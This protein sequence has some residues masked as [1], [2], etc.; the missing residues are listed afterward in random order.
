M[1]GA[2]SGRAAGALALLAAGVLAAGTAAPAG[3]RDLPD[4][5]RTMPPTDCVAQVGY[6]QNGELTGY[7][8]R[9]QGG[10]VVCVPIREIPRVD[11]AKGED[12][13]IDRATF[14]AAVAALEACRAAGPCAAEAAAAAYVPSS[15][16]KTGTKDPVGLIDPFAPDVDLADIRRPAYFAQAPYAEPIAAAEDS[17]WTL[18]LAVPADPYDRL[19]RGETADTHLRGW[20]L[21][22]A[23]V[24]GPDGSRQR[25]LVVLIGGR[26]VETTATDDPRDPTYV[27]TADGRY[28]YNTAARGEGLGAH[29]WRGYLDTM[30]R[31]GFDVLTVDKR[32]HGISGGRTPDDLLNQGLDMLRLLDALDDGDGLRVL[33]PDG[34][35]RAGTAA[36]RALIPTAQEARTVPTVLGGSSQGSETTEF[37]MWANTARWC[38]YDEPG[39]PCHAPW[40]HENVRGAIMLSAIYSPGSY[41]AP[42]LLPSIAAGALRNHIMRYPTSEPLASIGRW[43]AVLNVKG[44]WDDLPDGTFSVYDAHRRAGDDAQLFLVRGP[45]SEV[46][47]GD[48]I[49]ARVRARM[50]DFATDA[51]RG[52]PVTQR[53]YADLQDAVAASWPVYE[54]STAPTVLRPARAR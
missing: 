22:G 27:R 9:Q 51:V 20:Y 42:G 33:G 32:G 26:T 34:A 36:A 47:W 11:A 41:G 5:T 28:V 53:R 13:R 1:T 43:P 35:E 8:V 38:R 12:P 6:P 44:L 2:W 45:H 24:R 54:P 15:F 16:R 52:R 25:A 31:A 50:V 40:G 4:E 19:V 39:A 23:G 3:A 10:E 37:A 14:P 48:A 49:I 30:W 29:V 17:T 46:Q 7:R 18:D 21:R